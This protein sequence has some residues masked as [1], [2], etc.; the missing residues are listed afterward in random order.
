[1][2]DKNLER[3]WIISKQVDELTKNVARLTGLIIQMREL[4]DV[5]N[6]KLE[7]IVTV[8][9][10]ADRCGLEGDQHDLH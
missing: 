10:E 3:D 9:E 1:M 6:N 8:I 2:T 5:Y 4:F 7:R